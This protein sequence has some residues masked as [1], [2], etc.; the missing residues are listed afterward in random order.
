MHGL[1]LRDHARQINRIQSLDGFP[2][3]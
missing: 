2:A 1:H 3:A